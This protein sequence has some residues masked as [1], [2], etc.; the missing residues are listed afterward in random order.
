MRKRSEE[1]QSVLPRDASE[2]EMV[3]QT[4]KGPD[5]DSE[6]VDEGNSPEP[7]LETDIGSGGNG[8]YPSCAR[9]PPDRFGH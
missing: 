7:E 5:S 3:W 8:R 2:R 1:E 6:Q 9:H 4:S